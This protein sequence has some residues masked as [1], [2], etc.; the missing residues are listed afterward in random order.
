MQ[1]PACVMVSCVRANWEQIKLASHWVQIKSFKGHINFYSI[2]E[3]SHV[4]LKKKEKEIHAAS[5]LVN[6]FRQI[7]Q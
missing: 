4:A 3:Y 2:L 1:K 6:I 7:Y 5:L